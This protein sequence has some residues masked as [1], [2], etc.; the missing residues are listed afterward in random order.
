MFLSRS[1]VRAGASLRNTTSL[2]SVRAFTQSVPR[3]NEDSPFSSAGVPQETAA[4]SPVVD[5]G[6]F[7]E[8]NLQIE[9]FP[10][11]AQGAFDPSIT[12]KLLAP[13]DPD[14]IEI[15]PDGLIYLP[16]IKYRR[17]LN[18]S[19]GPGGWGM[20][21][22]SPHTFQDRILSRE[23]A[24][25]AMG[26][27]VGQAR[28]EQIVFDRHGFPTASEG[29]KSNALVRCCKDLGIASELWDPRFILEWKQKYA[30][31]RWVTDTRTNKKSKAWRRNDRVFD[32][33]L[34]E[35]TFSSSAAG[36][37]KPGVPGAGG[38]QHS[39]ENCHPVRWG[40][41][42]M[43][44]RPLCMRLW[45]G[46][47][48]HI[49]RPILII[50]TEEFLY[51]QTTFQDQQASAGVLRINRDDGAISLERE[52]PSGSPKLIDAFLGLIN[53]HSGLHMVTVEASRRVGRIGES[54]AVYMLQDVSITRISRSPEDNLTPVQLSTDRDHCDMIARL[55]VKGGFYF[56]P[57]Y[58][59]SRS[60]QAQRDLQQANPAYQDKL[61]SRRF[62]TAFNWASFLQ[63]PLMKQIMADSTGSLAGAAAF[64]MPI[65]CG[66][67]SI[68]PVTMSNGRSFDYILLTRRCVFR[69]GTRY[70][71]RGVD[72]TGRVANYNETEVQVRLA[73]ASGP[74]DI[75][76]YRQTRGSMPFYWR[77][78]T[79]L[80]YTPALEF[81]N[82]ALCLDVFKKHFNDE[83]SKYGDVVAVNLINAGG[84]EGRLGQMFGELIEN[85]DNPRVHYLHFDFHAESKAG[86]LANLTAKTEALGE[87]LA[88]QGF[89]HE[90]PDGQVLSRQHS[91]VRTNCMDC[92]DRTNVA[93]EM[94]A[95]LALV[96]FLSRSGIL[97]SASSDA[98]PSNLDY[99]LRNV[100]A[101]NADA[102]ST[103]Y[104][105]TGALKTDIT[106]TGKRTMR[107]ALQDGI[108]SLQRYLTN[109]FLDG[110]RQDAIDALLGQ[111]ST[112][113]SPDDDANAANKVVRPAGVKYMPFLFF[114]SLFNV[115]ATLVN[116][117]SSPTYTFL[118]LAFWSGLAFTSARGILN[119]GGHLVSRP[120]IWDPRS[121]RV[122]PFWS[123]SCLSDGDC[124]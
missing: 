72:S 105:G 31:E 60:L 61:L 94:F 74:G 97:S 51:L 110:R 118:I 36:G 4:R 50:L 38:G 84:Y 7:N 113:A 2:I 111:Q 68:S 57:T 120:R 101:D 11:I 95:R 122:K 100:W 44:A 96:D 102:V 33:P 86:R 16:E 40:S 42:H 92:L 77:Q 43:R 65:M 87:R 48:T 112:T 20:V 52:M 80:R 76:S 103:F 25:F 56:S 121:G 14:E 58:D 28:G 6:V 10:G 46:L 107:G 64:L 79:N 63:F 21:P 45:A 26:R 85:I 73:G 24:L 67:V 9:D 88:V 82:L 90:S 29:V 5:T 99:I 19:L 108:N 47:F 12:A 70:N 35:S 78:I 15:K 104:S 55:L 66:F 39:S 93:Q 30:V 37:A 109:Q 23:Y 116:R 13:L 59:L 41:M 32:A 75:M 54:D 106:R 119:N 69:A 3:R 71:T 83:V 115:A 117:P 18:A 22:R 81:D 124:Q 123:P 27:F 17:I 91:I 89:F 98:I 1:L 34:V 49:R 114:L 8:V 53:L 62:D